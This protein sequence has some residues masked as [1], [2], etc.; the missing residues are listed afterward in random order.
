[1]TASGG[2]KC[3]A[4]SVAM[5]ESCSSHDCPNLVVLTYVN[6]TRDGTSTTSV[7]LRGVLRN[8]DDHPQ[9][10]QV[11]LHGS[12][13]HRSSEGGSPCRSED[14]RHEGGGQFCWEEGPSKHHRQKER[15]RLFRGW[16]IETTFF[17]VFGDVDF[18]KS[19]HCCRGP[20]S[21]FSICCCHRPLLQALRE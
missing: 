19:E 2:T 8:S 5:I 17:V 15:G 3:S 18:S 14:H 9:G 13:D 7:R 6:E 21:G 10:V 20:T 4:C 12:G 1:M 11:N 16:V